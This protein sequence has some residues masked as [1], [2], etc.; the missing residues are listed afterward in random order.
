MV[1]KF[2]KFDIMVLPV[3]VKVFFALGLL[4]ILCSAVGFSIWFGFEPR[5]DTRPG[6]DFFRSM[7]RPEAEPTGSTFSVVR[8]IGGVVVA[9][10]GA[11][12]SAIWW[13]VICESTIILFK[14]HESLAAMK[15]REEQPAVPA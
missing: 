14:I 2:L 8:F 11:V 12:F 15:S 10:I 7:S 5:A 3:L 13:R 9:L 4:V 6:V 1:M